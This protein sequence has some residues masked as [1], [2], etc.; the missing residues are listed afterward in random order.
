MR[1]TTH[2]I[3]ARYKQ[4][5]NGDQMLSAWIINFSGNDCRNNRA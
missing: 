4:M 3:D 5:Q 1:L 2:E